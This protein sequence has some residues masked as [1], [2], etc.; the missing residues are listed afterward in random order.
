[1][2]KNKDNKDKNKYKIKGTKEI[3]LFIVN[4]IG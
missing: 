2:M 1:M 4:C 3:K